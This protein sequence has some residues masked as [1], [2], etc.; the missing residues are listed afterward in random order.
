MSDEIPKSNMK[1]SPVWTCGRCGTA[2]RP[3]AGKLV[4][5]VRTH[6]ELCTTKKTTTR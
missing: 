4:A 2:L 5:A 6:A 3:P 1:T